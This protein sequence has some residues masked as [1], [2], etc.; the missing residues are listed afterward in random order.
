MNQD[1]KFIKNPTLTV[2]LTRLHSGLLLNIMLFTYGSIHQTHDP[3]RSTKRA[4]LTGDEN[5]MSDADFC[6]RC[7][8]TSQQVHQDL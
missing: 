4:T 2:L 5:H 3:F 8:A 1:Q 6:P 7:G